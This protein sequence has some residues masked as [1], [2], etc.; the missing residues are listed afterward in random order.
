MITTQLEGRVI[1]VE[2]IA[3]AA[4]SNKSKNADE[5]SKVV[6]AKTKHPKEEKELNNLSSQTQ[7]KA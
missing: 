6:L 3:N 7:T 4:V 5:E 2:K 1:E